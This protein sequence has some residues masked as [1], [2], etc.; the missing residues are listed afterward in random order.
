MRQVSPRVTCIALLI[1]TACRSGGVTLPAADAIVEGRLDVP[2]ATDTIEE[3][4][5][6]RIDRAHWT[7]RTQGTPARDFWNDIAL[8]DIS[9]A[10]RSART[11]DERTFAAALKTL[12]SGDPDDAS[13]AFGALHVNATDHLVRSRARIGLT[14]A[15]SWQSDWP[16]LAAIGADP[17]SGEVSDSSAAQA[18][19]ERWGR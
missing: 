4:A 18:G 12:M 1:L 10:E 17:D 19:V 8:L 16:A 3:D 14:M 2:F 7:V 15:L 6:V 11:L 13:V 5:S 9:S